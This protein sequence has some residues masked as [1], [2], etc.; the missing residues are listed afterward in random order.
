MGASGS[1]DPRDPW[2]LQSSFC[3]GTLAR[4]AAHFAPPRESL[5]P[6]PPP[7]SRA[8][9]AGVEDAASAGASGAGSSSRSRGSTS[10]SVGDR[11]SGQAP[12]NWGGSFA[13]AKSAATQPWAASEQWATGGERATGA[14]RDAAARVVVAAAGATVDASWEEHRW[15]TRLPPRAYTV[16]RALPANGAGRLRSLFGAV[17]EQV[18]LPFVSGEGA[19]Q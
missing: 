7:P 1:D 16:V 6:L 11:G 10:R 15:P 14:R 17:L 2:R 5:Q 4:D 3:N 18:A 19:S 12:G 8:S 13:A 9:G